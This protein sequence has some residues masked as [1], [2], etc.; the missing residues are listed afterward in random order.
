MIRIAAGDLVQH[1]YNFG[2]SDLSTGFAPASD[3]TRQGM[4][5]R[6]AQSIRRD[7]VHDSQCRGRLAGDSSWSMSSSSGTSMALALG[8]TLP[9]I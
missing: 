7:H 4:S 1:L 9:L 2:A 6:S 3:S 8:C 5:S